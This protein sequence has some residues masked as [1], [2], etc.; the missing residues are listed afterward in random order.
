MA[1]T[2][3][4]DVASA[5]IDSVGGGF[6]ESVELAGSFG[7]GGGGCNTGEIIVNSKSYFYKQGGIQDYDMLRAEYEGNKEIDDTN[8]IRV[9]KPI[10]IGTSD[11]SSY[12]VFERLELG[13]PGDPS[14]Y[15]KDL[16]AMHRC[17]SAGKGYGWR[18]NNTCGVTPQINTW[19]MSWADFWCK[20][21]LGQIMSLSKRE[22]AS[23]DNEKEIL[24]KTH[25]VLSF[26]EREHNLQP[27]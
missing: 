13:G 22:G 2:F 1:T 23:F 16:A 8:T 7:S 12:A 26:H 4:S 25:E 18:M 24:A 27:R 14:R 6:V 19:E 11:Y 21:R 9:P 10:A 3:Q 17:S 20:H 15:A 5:I